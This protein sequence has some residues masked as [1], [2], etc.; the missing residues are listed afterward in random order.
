MCVFCIVYS[1]PTVFAKLGFQQR[2]CF[3]VLAAL[4]YPRLS[5]FCFSAKELHEEYGLSLEGKLPKDL[6]DKDIS[7]EEWMRVLSF[8]QKK[9][10]KL[11]LNHVRDEFVDECR[12]LY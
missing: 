6:A 3:V 4:E 2:L 12:M 7:H 9:S 8:L 1:I 5:R 11:F 10:T